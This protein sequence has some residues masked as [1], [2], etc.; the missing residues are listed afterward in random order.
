MRK[1]GLL[2]LLILFLIFLAIFMIFTDRWLENR[3]EAFGT[4]I[5]GARVEFD[6]VDFSFL[7]LRMQWQRLQVT[8]P[9]DTWRNL[10]ETGKAEFD[11]DLVPLFS[12][13]IIIENLSLENLQLNT[14]RE[15]DG[16]VE[17]KQEATTESKIE[18]TIE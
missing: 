13:K 10:F 9:D 16:K 15:T 5:V 14:E 8:N 11:L 17:K 3:M 4:S 2:L 18:K 7:K 12:R 1:K 6:G